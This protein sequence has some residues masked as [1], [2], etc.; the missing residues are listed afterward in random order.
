MVLANE[1]L[2]LLEQQLMSPIQSKVKEIGQS[3]RPPLDVYDAVI[4]LNRAVIARRL[5]TFDAPVYG[6][7]LRPFFSK[8]TREYK[9]LPVYDFEPVDCLLKE[10][11][12]CYGDKCR[13]FYDRYGGSLIGVM[14]IDKAWSVPSEFRVSHIN[15][16]TLVAPST[17]SGE[18]RL[19][20]NLEAICQDFLIIGHGL[21][22]SVKC[23]SLEMKN[24]E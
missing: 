4:H 6:K 18:K 12:T 3:F 11:R 21:V 15:A 2:K 14:W 1:S 8:D 13:F 23:G 5:Y 16:S 10:L 22:N 17:T 19:A 24:S 7:K 20:P 9:P